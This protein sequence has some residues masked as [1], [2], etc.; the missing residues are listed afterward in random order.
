MNR[1]N[2]CLDLI[3]QQINDE[4]VVA[5]WFECITC[6][7]FDAETH[8]L[9]LGVP[10]KYVV[11]FVEH[12]YVRLLKQVITRVYGENVN[13]Q[14]HLDS[15]RGQVPGSTNSIEG[16]A[17]YLSPGRKVPAAPQAIVNCQLSIVNSKERLQ[18]GLQHFLG[19][20][21]RWL[22]EYDEIADWLA[23]NKG[24]GLLLVGTSGLGKSL[25]CQ[26]ILPVL[27]SDVLG[28]AVD[29]VSAREMGQQIDSLVQSRC[30]II[31]DLG[32]EPVTEMV[33]YRK[34]TP[35]FELCDAAEQR[36]ILLIINT[37]LSTNKIN[38][39]LYPRSI[40]ERYGNE[41]LDRLRATT[42]VVELRG[43]SMRK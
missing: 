36:G 21:A 37:T 39:P 27:L 14:Y 22:P 18:K 34:R 20:D 25:I 28:I 5:T 4:W 29:V 3:R 16:S 1:W 17:R 15:A 35:F 11:E 7:S 31:D 13:L 32:H 38:N 30:V 2:E 12:Y 10:S 26:K 24:R 40:Q 42:R 8:V 19:D 9:Q 23:D 6:E 33:A 43:Q 41:V